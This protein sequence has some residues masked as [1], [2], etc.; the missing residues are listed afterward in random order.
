MPDR[1]SKVDV[2]IVGGGTG[3]C[4]AALAAAAAGC[5]VILAESSDWL[6]GQMTS[7]AVPP[8]ENPWI[9][10]FGC[11]RRYRQYRN[12]VRQY[13]R[14]W[15]PLTGE[16]IRNPTL[17]PGNGM[18]S[19]LCHEP[20]VGLAVIEG[21]MAPYRSRGVL[22][23][24]LNRIG[25]S[26][27][28]D[29]DRVRTVTLQDIRN[30]D[31]ETVEARY[32]LDATE[33]GDLLPDTGTEYVSGAES[34]AETGE[35]H[36]AAQANPDNVQALTWCFPVAHD[37]DGSRVIDRPDQWEKWRDYIPTLTP[38]WPG[39]LLAWEWAHPVTLKPL[40]GILLP[41]EAAPGRMSLWLYRRIICRD[42]YA[43][44]DA[45]HEVTLVN[46]PHNDYLETNIIDKERKVVIEAL[47]DAK[48]LSLSLL[49][50][51]QTEAPRPDGRTGY[52]GLYLRPDLTGTED[53]LAKEP[54]IRESRRIRARFT[55]TEMHVGVQARASDQAESF[56]DSVG[57]G[58]YRI[59]LHP[60]T[61]GDN[62]IDVDSYPFQ[63]PL[64]ALVPIR[65]RNLLPACKNLGVTH[66][67]NGCFRL[68]P[69]E[70]NIGESAGA[71]AAFCVAH[72]CEPGQVH[73]SPNLLADFQRA[74]TDQGVEIAWPRTRRV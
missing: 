64:G 42:H 58:C 20:R 36:A 54:Y 7:Q 73:S 32:I 22:D 37:P 49:Y 28:V 16:A 39:K 15:Y 61:G 72:D 41:E 44:G 63:I 34:Q 24:R 23:V 13:M 38:A 19:R 53:G 66:I 31:L 1:A 69:V 9:E 46:W 14:D 18:V 45:P 3:G 67:T 47:N 10:Q 51:L 71:L 65:M 25:L 17:N 48:Q 70:W 5:S 62:Y 30:G 11:T 52:P 59:D 2:L 68:H 74:L 29:G 40:Q 35:L 26:A 60:S 33:L 8:D 57:I 55:V 6:G 56:P 43:P 50:W 21:M 12:G 27:Q 4:A